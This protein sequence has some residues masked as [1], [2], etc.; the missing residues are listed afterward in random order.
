MIYIEAGIGYIMVSLIEETKMETCA[1]C[2][3][4]VPA[5]V[6]WYEQGEPIC[7]KCFDAEYGGDSYPSYERLDNFDPA[8]H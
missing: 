8:G 1:G 6:A 7:P 3:C 4:S 5:E 2:G